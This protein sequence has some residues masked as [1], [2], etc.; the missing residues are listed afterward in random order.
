MCTN[1]ASL[2]RSSHTEVM[3]QSSHIS[4]YDS[5]KV[6]MAAI[7]AAGIQTS[8]EEADGKHDGIFR[9][10]TARAVLAISSVALLL[11]SLSGL[12]STTGAPN[13]KDLSDTVMH[14]TQQLQNIGVIEEKNIHELEALEHQLD[15][16]EIELAWEKQHVGNEKETQKA[17]FDSM[18][19]QIKKDHEVM[20]ENDKEVKTVARKTHQTLA[21]L[22]KEQRENA[23]LK[24]ALAF[25]LEELAKARSAHPAPPPPPK[26]VVER[27][28]GEVGE[29]D[30][31]ER[32]LRGVHASPYQPGD[33]IEIIEYEE[34]GKVALRPGIVSDVNADGTYNLVKL[35]QSML[36]KNF[37]REQ[38]QTYHIYYE[39]IT[40][41]YA[42]AQ[43]V[44]VPITIVQLVPGSYREGLELHGKYQFTFDRDEK[45]EI[46]EDLATRIH[47]FAGVG[48]IVGE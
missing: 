25:A 47:R 2:R 36:I 32:K 10:S 1:N 38:F 9:S 3:L 43:E 28:K 20:E 33:N 40:A 24:H 7:Y 30:P 26:R 19:T 23:H 41:L 45:K 11:L 12:G 5:S 46:H 13:L 27:R 34:G 22:E 17:M 16:T 29:S 44:Y 48:E 39:G 15:E 31:T 37:R 14:L 8:D 42:E 4:S 21:E 35:E 6:Q 18:L